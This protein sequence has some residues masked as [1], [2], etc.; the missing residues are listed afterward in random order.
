MESF[1][2]TDLN[3]ACREKD[4]SKI[5]FFGAY[6]AALSFIIN[7]ANQNRV[8]E[9]LQDVTYLYR[10]IKLSLVEVGQYEAGTTTNLLG[11]TS[12]SKDFSLALR[13]SFEFL[14]ED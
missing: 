1:I 14:K 3:R 10:G 11:Y 2:Y 7:S 12:T 9:K 4:K 8:E 6:A 5:K 13:F